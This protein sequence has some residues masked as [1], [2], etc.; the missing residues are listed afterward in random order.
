MEQSI[1]IECGKEFRF[2][3]GSYEFDDGDMCPSCY[4]DYCTSEDAHDE[5]NESE[6]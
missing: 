4:N 3:P 5:T 2:G 1:C 6:I